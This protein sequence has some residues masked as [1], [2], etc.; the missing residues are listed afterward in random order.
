VVDTASPPHCFLASHAIC[1]SDVVQQGQES[2]AN[3][4]DSR[5]DASGIDLAR[6]EVRAILDHMFAEE[7]LPDRTFVLLVDEVMPVFQCLLAAAEHRGGASKAYVG[8]AGTALGAGGPGQPPLSIYFPHEHVAEVCPVSGVQPFAT[9]RSTPPPNVSLLWPLTFTE[10]CE[11]FLK[12]SSPPEGDSDPLDWSLKEWRDN[13]PCPDSESHQFRSILRSD[14]AEDDDR[15]SL[16]CAVE[17]ICSDGQG[18]DS[19]P[20]VHVQEQLV[21]GLVTLETPLVLLLLQLRGPVFDPLLDVTV[22]RLPD[23][24]CHAPQGISKLCSFRRAL[25]V[26]IELAVGALILLDV[27]EDVE[28]IRNASEFRCAGIFTRQ[29]VLQC[30]EAS[31]TQSGDDFCLDP[32][33]TVEEVLH[34]LHRVLLASRKASA[35]PEAPVPDVLPGF[36][37]GGAAL[38]FDSQVTLREAI[39]TTM[40]SESRRMFMV[41]QSDEAPGELVGSRVC[42]VITVRDIWR[43]ILGL[44]PGSQ[45]EEEAPFLI[46]QHRRGP[47]AV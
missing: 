42:R 35:T 13:V 17:A 16:R 3:C 5:S 1:M 4:P 9:V 43:L 19:L 22:S 33:A 27:S 26:F 41:D 47:A 15:P 32:D 6:I 23:D 37:N 45:S 38:V 2:Q 7:G 14:I 46:R 30:L 40:T 8:P 12:A 28:L 36:V 29:H 31:A 44:V 21:G 10:I 24:D 39:L 25:R 11:W 18:Y 34:R 20:L